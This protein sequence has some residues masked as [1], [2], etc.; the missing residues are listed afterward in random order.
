MSTANIYVI[1]YGDWTGNTGKTLIPN[2]FA[3]IGTSDWYSANDGYYGHDGV[4]VT[5]NVN[6]MTSINDNYS[7]GKNLGIQEVA[8][9]VQNALSSSSLPSDTD[10][11]YFVL[12]APD[13]VGTD[14][15]CTQYCGYHSFFPYVGHNYKFSLVI[16]SET[17]CPQSCTA[18]YV[19][20]PN[21]NPGV[22]G[23]VRPLLDDT[24]TFCE[25]QRHC[26]RTFRGRVRSFAGR[27]VR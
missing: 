13:V 15:F 5:Q 8:T 6:Y 1:W 23:M 17:Q 21:D 3:N 14:G 16:N 10:G 26:P 11:I 18:Q 4:Y 25:D 9:I 2:F 19:A 24:D 7:L 27:L 12:G 22:D 20:S